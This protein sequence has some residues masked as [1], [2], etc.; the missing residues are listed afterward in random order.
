MRAGN[1]VAVPWGL[2][3]VEVVVL[4]AYAS[5]G[6]DRLLVAFPDELFGKPTEVALPADVARLLPCKPL[7]LWLKKYR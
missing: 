5:G 1:R 3:E 2:D 7:G 4:E 6:R